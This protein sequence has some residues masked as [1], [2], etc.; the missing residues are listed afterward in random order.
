MLLFEF[1]KSILSK[2]FYDL[3]KWFITKKLLNQDS[4]F[5][6]KYIY[7]KIKIIW[8]AIMFYVIFF[9]LKRLMF[10][11]SFRYSNKDL[12][13]KI[14]VVICFVVLVAAVIICRNSQ[15]RLST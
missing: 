4:K 9:V 7:R 5:Y 10:S 12:E 6:Y 1:L 2:L 13:T 15:R 8:L 3:A 11:N 14:A